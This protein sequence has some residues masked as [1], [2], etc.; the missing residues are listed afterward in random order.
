MVVC[1]YSHIRIYKY[2]DLHIY[3]NAKSLCVLHVC[4]LL[5]I[6]YSYLTVEES[7]NQFW[8]LLQLPPLEPW[9]SVSMLRDGD[10]LPSWLLKKESEYLRC[11]GNVHFIIEDHCL[12]KTDL[13]IVCRVFA[14]VIITARSVTA[15]LER[16]SE[17]SEAYESGRKVFSKIKDS[18]ESSIQQ[19][20]SKRMVGK[21]YDVALA[22]VAKTGTKNLDQQSLFIV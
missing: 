18:K 20:G 12:L 6:A 22:Y 19:S 16:T 8:Q 3:L 10:L 2:Y 13:F 14:A 11:S 21:T 17:T 9:C 15:A 1:T 4:L 5:S 7:R